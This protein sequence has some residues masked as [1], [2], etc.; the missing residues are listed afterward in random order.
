M[1][2]A[3]GD[4]SNLLQRAEVTQHNVVSFKGQGLKLDTASDAECVIEAM[5]KASDLQVLE[6]SGNTLGVEAAEAIAEELKSH[7]ELERCLWADMYTGRLRKEIPPSLTALGNSMIA[8]K[9]H[10]VEIDLSHNAFGPIGITS[11]KNL[12]MDEACY[13]LEI[14]KFNNNGMGI[15]GKTLSEAL[16]ECHRRSSAAGKPLALKVF[17]AGRNR[18]E[19]PGA[20]ALAEAFKTIGTLEEIHMPQNGINHQGITALAEAVKNCQNL[21]HINLNDN[22]FT[23]NGAVSM[24]Q[25]INEITQLEVIDFGDCLVRTKGAMHIGNAL[26]KS[27][28]NLKQLMLCN[29]EIKLDGGIRV[30]EGIARKE[31]LELIDLNGNEF[32]ADGVEEITDMLKESGHIEALGSLSDDEGEE[33]DSEG[34]VEEESEEENANVPASTANGTVQTYIS[35][36]DFPD[37]VSAGSLLTLE[38]TKR[39]D[40]V[41]QA[42]L[43]LGNDAERCVDDCAKLSGLLMAH[44]VQDKAGLEN[45]IYDCADIYFRT[46]FRICDDNPMTVVNRILIRAG[47]IKSEDKIINKDPRPFLQ[48]LNNAMRKT[49]FPQSTMK[50]VRAMVARSSKVWEMN[51]DIQGKM[52]QFLYVQA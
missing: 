17:I 9:A 25:A 29:G 44:G 38:I 1:N 36:E 13:T 37:N 28:P 8:A 43:R 45:T 33:S 7:Q 51:Y 27:N 30:C 20:I 47:L 2:D 42:V 14:L 24:A 12:L 41:Q 5:K 11:I 19:N 23:E 6:L 4:L 16:I 48:V 40:L 34:I 50:T 15:G 32:G 52:L 31:F 22:T 49:Y 39:N 10:L 46:A 35:V 3:V 18:L 26:Q 21:R